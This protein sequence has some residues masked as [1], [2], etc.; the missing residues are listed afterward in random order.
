MRCMHETTCHE[1]NVF[2]TLTYDEDHLPAK[3]SLDR[4]AF[5]LF[6]RAL[7]KQIAPA[8]VRYFYVG[9]YGTRSFRPHYHALLFG[10][11][12]S[13]AAL[14]AV[15]G[16]HPVFTSQA[17]SDVW[18]QGLHEFGEVTPASALYVAG[19]MKRKMT[20]SWAKLKYGERVPEFG[21]MS[22]NPGIGAGWIDKFRGEVYPSGEVPVRGLMVKAPRY[23][24]VRAAAVMPLEVESAR[25]SRY[26]KR[27]RENETPERLAV[28]EVCAIAREDLNESRH[29]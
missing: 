5:P 10:Y 21:Q 27:V 4:K 23:Y 22:R 17:L 28:M 20:G 13:D 14:L 12:P 7:R 29:L 3:A 9:E 1:E 24:D 26:S 19:Y 15:R 6:V 25:W 11:R 18:T 2:L 16:D 8:K